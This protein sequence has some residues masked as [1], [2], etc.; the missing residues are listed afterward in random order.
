MRYGFV[1]KLNELHIEELAYS[2]DIQRSNDPEAEQRTRVSAAN[3]RMLENVSSQPRTALTRFLGAAS[4]VH[5][6]GLV[7]PHGGPRSS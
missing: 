7:W 5:P 4:L 3:W 1:Q 6:A 2:D